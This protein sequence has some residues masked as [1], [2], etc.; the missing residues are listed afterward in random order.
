MTNRICPVHWPADRCEA[1]FDRQQINTC[2]V[3]FLGDESK[4]QSTG[5]AALYL[6]KSVSEVVWALGDIGRRGLGCVVSAGRTGIAGGAVPEDG[7]AVISLADMARPL[8]IDR[9]G[10]EYW[11]RVEPGYSLAQLMGL[12]MNADYARL[13]GPTAAEMEVIEALH[14]SGET[15]WFPVNPTET[16]AHIGGIVATNASGARSYRYGA[17]REWV[18]GLKVV[19]ADGRLLNVRRGEVRAQGGLFLLEQQDGSAKEIVVTA[20]PWPAT[21]ATLGYPL[22]P[23]MD[24]IDLFI[25]SE[26]S[27]GV[28]VEVELALAPKPESTVGVLAL[29]PSEDVAL[30]LVAEA[31]V[32]AGLVA[33]A[34]EYFDRAALQMIKEKKAM[35]GASGQLPELPCWDAYGV[36]FEF[37]GSEEETEAACELLEEVLTD[38][39]LSLDDTWAAMEPAEMAAQRLFRHTVPEAVNTRIGQYRQTCPGLHKVG[40][41]MA[42]PDEQ[43]FNLFSLY[44]EGIE[45]V[46]IDSVIFG[47]IGN[48]HVHVNLLPKTMA[49]LEKAKELYRR[50]AVQVVA[51]GGAV[52][53]EHG[54]GRLKKTLLR[55]QFGDDSLEGMRQVRR[56]FDPA[57]I[58]ARG[59][60]FD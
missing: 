44:R 24:L 47:H 51:M 8:G 40:T 57:H 53:A 52:A 58:L 26:G 30:G 2:Y 54:V 60:L 7:G 42:V 19:L 27:L 18:R 4:L 39:G 10:S 29:A 49:E 37:A 56:L 12:L 9:H 15:L 38:A 32:K 14:D 13:A 25:G 55:L 31:R 36:Y 1:V 22:A 20:P 41:D 43:L 23:D 46:S 16:S 34:I 3:D 11:I 21:K 17:T 28:I 45:E 48:N 59:V 5:I 35:D 6:P 50:W 33:D